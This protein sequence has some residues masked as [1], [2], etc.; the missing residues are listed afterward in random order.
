[1]QFETTKQVEILE[2]GNVKYWK[3]CSIA[4]EIY[5]VTL[6]KEQNEKYVENKECI[7][8]YLPDLSSYQREFLISRLTPLEWEMMFDSPFDE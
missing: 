4:N 8:D 6:T 3:E 5:S 2:N 7:Q 1:M